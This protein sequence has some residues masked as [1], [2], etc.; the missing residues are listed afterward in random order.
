MTENASTAYKPPAKIEALLSRQQEEGYLSKE[1]ITEISKDLGVPIYESY[2]IASF[3]P[4]FHLE[5]PAKPKVHI[6]RDMSCLLAGGDSLLDNAKTLIPW[7]H[8]K[9]VLHFVCESR[10]SR[11]P[12]GP[13]PDLIMAHTARPTPPT[14]LPAKTGTHGGTRRRHARPLQ[15]PAGRP[16]PNILTSHVPESRSHPEPTHVISSEAEKSETADGNTRG[17]P[18]PVPEVRRTPPP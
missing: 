17:N 3:F 9:L 8:L 5:K 15:L 2:G 11:R 1:A 4:H 7:Q 16:P 10:V 13:H 12:A 14:D 6:C 18:S